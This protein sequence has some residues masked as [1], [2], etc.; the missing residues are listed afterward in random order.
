MMWHAA[1][2]VTRNCAGLWQYLAERVR[3]RTAVRLEQE[4]NQATAAVL[5]VLPPG[6]ELLEYEP[7]GRLRIIRLPGPSALTAILDTQTMDEA[8][9]QPGG[10]ALK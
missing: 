1:L 6:G 9:C 4:R 2:G 7:Q 8:L 3:G 10:G 5:G